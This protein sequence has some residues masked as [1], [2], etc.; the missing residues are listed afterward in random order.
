MQDWLVHGLL[1]RQQ[2]AHDPRRISAADSDDVQWRHALGKRRGMGVPCL[3]QTV[4]ALPKRAAA[5]A[6]SEGL[7]HSKC[8]AA[9]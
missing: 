3:E 6:A 5:R 4:R 2:I 9:R 1:R 7:R 8:D